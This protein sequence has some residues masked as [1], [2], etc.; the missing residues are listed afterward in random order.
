[1]G[2]NK[3]VKRRFSKVHW[4]LLPALDR[5]TLL[6]QGGQ[7]GSLPA[8]G[9]RLSVASLLRHTLPSVGLW[10]RLQV[11]ALT[12]PPSSLSG[13]VS[14]AHARPSEP[15]AS[16]RQAYPFHTLCSLCSQ[17]PPL[18]GLGK[19]SGTLSCLRVERG[20][21]QGKCKSLP[22]GLF[23]ALCPTARPSL[24]P[25]SAEQCEEG[26]WGRETRRAGRSVA[27]GRGEDADGTAPRGPSRSGE[28]RDSRLRDDLRHIK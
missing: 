2:A 6:P 12:A 20:T 14:L 4:Q 26:D 9:I 8:S 23:S 18:P 15:S 7:A 10:S 11:A 13:S 19:A 22:G 28:D 16:L 5:V 21:A 1:M 24:V 25:G 3:E 17:T 27:A